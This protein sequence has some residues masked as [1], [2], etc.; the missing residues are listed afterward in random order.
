MPTTGLWSNGSWEG[1]GLQPL[2]YG[3]Q[4]LDYSLRR[5][6]AEAVSLPE[7]ASPFPCPSQQKQVEVAGKLQTKQYNTQPQDGEP[8]SSP[9]HAQEEPKT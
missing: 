9:P 4:P 8:A 5:K 6:R 3:L 7:K 1:V 2:D